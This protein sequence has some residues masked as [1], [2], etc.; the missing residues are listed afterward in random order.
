M[1]HPSA[2]DRSVETDTAKS[3]TY[4]DDAPLL[5]FDV[6]NE[7]I[8][9]AKQ[10]FEALLGTAG[11]NDNLGDRVSQSSTEWSPAPKSDDI[12]ALIVYPTSTEDVSEIAKICH[13]RRIPMIGF[14]GGT[15]LEGALAATEGGIFINFRKMNKIMVLHERDLDVV[16]QPAVGWEELNEELAKHKLFFPPDPGK[17]LEYRSVLLRSD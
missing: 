15:S 12:P 2:Q 16:V 14:S 4:V 13:R 7:N 10:E 3:I 6:S 17:L 5:A 8:K 1:R 9:R 11:V